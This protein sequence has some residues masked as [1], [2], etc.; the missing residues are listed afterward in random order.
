[1]PGGRGSVISCSI[2]PDPERLR[3]YTQHIQQTVSQVSLD[4]AGRWY[5]QLAEILGRQNVSVDGVPLDSRVAT[6]LTVAD[7]AMKR[8]AL[9]V[10]PSGVREIKS[11]LALAGGD[12]RQ[13]QALAREGLAIRQKALRPD[14]PDVGTSL[15]T[16]G[17]VL[18]A[19][20][21]D[22]QAEDLL[23]QGL[24]ILTGGL[25]AGHWR[26]AEARSRLG[27]VLAERGHA[28]D[29]VAVLVGHQDR[30]EVLGRQAE[31]REAEHGVAHAEAAVDHHPR[32]IRFDDEA[33]AL[34]AGADRGEAHGASGETASGAARATARGCARCCW[35]CR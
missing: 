22:P 5:A 33:V 10:D 7:F 20:G 1:M 26:I 3:K 34:A 19:A 2:D 17:A 21:P 11:Q 30:V 31:A 28:T 4:S 24:T 9:G 14:H 29:V 13:A 23:R 8:I 6:T 32:A 15:V 35:S 12:L 18:A 25:P 27:A 16:L